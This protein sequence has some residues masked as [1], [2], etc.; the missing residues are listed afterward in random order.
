M[1]ERTIMHQNA[2]ISTL[3]KEKSKRM[4]SGDSIAKALAGKLKASDK[5]ISEV[6]N[7]GAEILK[8]TLI[9]LQSID[10]E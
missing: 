7:L 1:L 6:E 8:Q 4:K 9:S 5:R 3:E 10:Y 2:R